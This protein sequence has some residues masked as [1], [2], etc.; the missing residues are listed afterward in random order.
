MIRSETWGKD[1][2]GNAVLLS[3]EELPD[4]PPPEIVSPRQ[5]KLALLAAGKLDDVESFV[6]NAERAVQ[7]S[8]EYAVEWRRDDAMLNDM[9][10]AFGMSSEEV[11]DLFRVAAEL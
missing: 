1:E 11:D 2:D 9:A 4:P 3:V 8:W 6:A 5:I 10:S 7:I